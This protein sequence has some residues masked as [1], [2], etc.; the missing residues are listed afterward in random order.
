MASIEYI[1]SMPNSHFN[2]L[3]RWQERGCEGES[4]IPFV[5]WSRANVV[6]KFYYI[7]T[8]LH[9]NKAF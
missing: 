1:D 9:Q 7:V 2:A 6:H 8:V 4:F 3:C 5:S